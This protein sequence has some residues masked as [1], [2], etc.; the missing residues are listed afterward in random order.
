[1]MRCLFVLFL[2]WSGAAQAVQPD[3]ILPDPRLEARAR[4]ISK[5]LR[6]LVCQ[7]ESIDDS[8]ADLA[9]DLRRIVRERLVAGDSDQAVLDYIVARYGN[10]V[11]MTPPFDTST[12]LLWL[13]PFWGLVIGGALVYVTLLRSSRL[14][15]AD[16]PLSL[17]EEDKLKAALSD[18][19]KG[20]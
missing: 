18:P 19:P 2:L 3:E 9:K 15:P 10:F 8:E 11:R 12:I 13:G 1:M 7:N 17:E 5:E 16:A 14:R 20:R 6:C 4:E